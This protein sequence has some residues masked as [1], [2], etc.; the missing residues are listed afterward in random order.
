MN[1]ENVP[2]TETENIFL[3]L[4]TYTYIF[5]KPISHGTTKTS[6]ARETYVEFV[7]VR[8][9]RRCGIRATERGLC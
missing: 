4:V 1:A 7:V 9:P 8:R 5:V 3:L 6:A 2:F